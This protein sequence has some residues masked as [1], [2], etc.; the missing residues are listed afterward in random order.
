MM[1]HLAPNAP[2]AS[3]PDPL[4]TAEGVAPRLQ[5]QRFPEPLVNTEHPAVIEG[6]SPLLV[7]GLRGNGPDTWEFRSSTYE[8][9]ARQ[10]L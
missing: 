8:N 4:L 10:Q 2:I 6:R 7:S 5:G 3:H 9:G 1:P